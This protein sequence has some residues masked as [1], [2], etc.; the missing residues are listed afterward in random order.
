MKRLHGLATSVPPALHFIALS[1]EEL[2]QRIAKRAE[3]EA[4]GLVQPWVGNKKKASGATSA[5]SDS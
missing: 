5:T 1:Q 3:D 2:D 4:N